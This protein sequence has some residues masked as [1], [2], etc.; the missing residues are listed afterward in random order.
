MA[1]AHDFS[2]SYIETRLQEVGKSIIAAVGEQMEINRKSCSVDAKRLDSVKFFP[3][4]TVRYA[5][6]EKTRFG[7]DKQEHF[8]NDGVLFVRPGQWGLNATPTKMKAFTVG[9]EI[10]ERL[11]DLAGDEKILMYMGWTDFYFLV[12]PPALESAAIAK[13]DLI[14]DSRLGLFVLDARPRVVRIPLRQDSLYVN[15]YALAMQCLFSDRPYADVEYEFSGCEDPADLD[16]SAYQNAFRKLHPEFDGTEDTFLRTKDNML[17]GLTGKELQTL[18]EGKTAAAIAEEEQERKAQRK[19]AKLAREEALAEALSN[20][21]SPEVKKRLVVQRND[22][23]TVY[24]AIN[25]CNSESTITAEKL[26]DEIGIS[27]RTVEA[28]L[29]SLRNAGLIRSEGSKKKP[30]IAVI[31]E[32]DETDDFAKCS[33]FAAVKSPS[34]RRRMQLV[35]SEC[36]LT[37]CPAHP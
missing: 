15:K 5:S 9:L 37:E 4:V 14:G 24:H 17:G 11:E 3:E 1:A 28:S 36:P 7:D 26:A 25:R 18:A 35:C 16:P 6:G 2:K 10:K 33:L 31:S 23:Q 21:N 19:A 27:K 22:A 12:V 32:F 8:R 34:E 30:Q 13:L 20:L 29:A